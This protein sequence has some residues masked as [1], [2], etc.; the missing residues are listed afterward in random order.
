MVKIENGRITTQYKDEGETLNDMVGLATVIANA[1]IIIYRKHPQKEMNE[2]AECLK[3]IQK[4]CQELL[5]KLDLANQIA[6]NNKVIPFPNKTK[7]GEND[8]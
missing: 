3:E 1:E 6:I 5:N 8:K 2:F 7:E 4:K